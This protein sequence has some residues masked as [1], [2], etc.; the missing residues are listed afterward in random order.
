MSLATSNI[1]AALDT[2]KAK[3]NTSS[4]DN[5]KKKKK[6]DK[7]SVSTADLEKA[8]F[9]QPSITISSWADEEDDEFTVAPLPPTWDQV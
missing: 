6:S 7:R 4:K 9:S 2:K 1:F 5:D 8:I 3:K